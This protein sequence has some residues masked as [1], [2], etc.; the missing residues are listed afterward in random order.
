MCTSSTFHTAG[1]WTLGGALCPRNPWGPGRETPSRA[2]QSPCSGPPADGEMRRSHVLPW[3][4]S[5]QA[6]TG[7][8]DEAH[9]SVCC[10][11]GSCWGRC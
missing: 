5:F 4:V 6:L 2:A 11:C 8:S 1:S 7:Y 3:Q 10:M 9:Y